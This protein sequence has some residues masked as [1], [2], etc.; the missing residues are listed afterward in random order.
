MNDRLEELRRKIAALAR[1]IDEPADT[2]P[3]TTTLFDK[4]V[5]FVFDLMCNG[6]FVTG[7]THRWLAQQWGL[8]M[9]YVRTVTQAASL[10][11]KTF[12]ETSDDDRQNLSL[13]VRNGFEEMAS[14]AR[15]MAGKHGPYALKVAG[16]LLDKMALYAGIKPADKLEHTGKD[17]APLQPGV[18]LLPTKEE[19][20]EEPDESA[21][22]GAH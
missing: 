19:E 11:Y 17:G 5:W 1:R 13:R 3:E 10:L 20:P 8:S 15:G 21:G 9:S 18:V 14:D 22:D 6:S 12:Y 4:R 2:A 7:K 16:E